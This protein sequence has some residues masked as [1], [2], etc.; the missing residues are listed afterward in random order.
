MLKSN[1]SWNG[2]HFQ[3]TMVKYSSGMTEI[4]WDNCLRKK[5]KWVMCG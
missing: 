2:F 4:F 3:G 5:V 1:G